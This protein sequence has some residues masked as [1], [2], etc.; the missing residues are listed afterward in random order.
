[1]SFLHALVKAMFPSRDVRVDVLPD[2]DAVRRELA[3]LQSDVVAA[4]YWTPVPKGRSIGAAAATGWHRRVAGNRELMT[5]LFRALPGIRVEGRHWWY[6]ALKGGRR[7]WLIHDDFGPGL[8][9][10]RLAAFYEVEHRTLLRDERHIL[11]GRA[12]CNDRVK[13]VELTGQEDDVPGLPP[14]EF[15]FAAVP[16]L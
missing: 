2:R 1:M 6:S 15:D 7:V 16:Y 13:V 5:F 4:P 9:P 8:P 14:P 3:N 10:A 12:F 11:A